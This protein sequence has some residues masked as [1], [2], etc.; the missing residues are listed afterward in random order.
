M[1]AV[2]VDLVPGTV[3][4]TSALLRWSANPTRLLRR[5]EREGTARSLGQG[6]F[7]VPRTSRFGEV[8]PSVRALLD[9]FL[10]D[11]PYVVTGL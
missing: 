6:L 9:A 10:D 7:L 3:Y 8:P 5:L 4:R 11:T 2:Q 1:R